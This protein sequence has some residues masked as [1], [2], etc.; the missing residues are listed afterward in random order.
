MRG[1]RRWDEADRLRPLQVIAALLAAALLLAAS[2]PMWATGPE[3]PDGQVT[4]SSDV[5]ARQ[6]HMDDW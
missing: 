5:A 6:S 2:A 4:G 3:H 1:H